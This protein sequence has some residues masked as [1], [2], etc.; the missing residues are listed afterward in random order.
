MRTL[1][2]P[3]LVRRLTQSAA[4]ASLLVA[5]V[6]HAQGDPKFQG[7]A[8]PD[9]A[10]AP[11]PAPAPTPAPAPAADP[12]AAANAEADA[13]AAEAAKAEAA[14]KAAE[15][16]ARAVE[17][18]AQ[19]KGGLV[20]TSGNSQTTNA[21]FG[22]TAS[23]KQGDNKLALEGGIAYGKSQILV[24]PAT[25]VDTNNLI[26][27]VDREE[28][29]TTNMW[30]GKGRYDRFLTANN[31]AYV[32]G[33]LAADKVSG[34]KLFGGGQ[35]GYSRQLLKDDMNLMV[36]E[37][38][39]DFSYES[40]VQSG[41]DAVAIHSARVFIGETLKLTPETGLIF[42]VEALLNLNKESKA[43]SV[44]T[45]KTSVDALKDTRV[46]GKLGITTN[47]RKNL[48]M[49]LG[50]SLK[51]DQNPALRPVPAGAPAGA[52]FAGDGTTV[53]YP[54]VAFADKTDTITEA[55]LIYTFF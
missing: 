48:S 17:W 44:S 55:T 52:K 27:D 8:A 20:L 39:Y 53:A 30:S 45:G 1:A 49:G 3:A 10:A 19:S 29:I 42:S 38:G 21:T 23:R 41:L 32:S 43:I 11:A 51:Y 36:A 35:A 40:Y 18:K 7:F 26:T 46:N 16:A 31:S 13:K 6:A 15:A 9:P 24:V 2:S 25:G 12:A 14:A 47:L 22:V 33:Q 28:R 54:S 37:L 5:G 50:V 4:L 34:K